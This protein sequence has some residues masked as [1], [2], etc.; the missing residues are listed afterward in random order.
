VS[1]RIVVFLKHENFDL[2]QVFLHDIFPIEILRLPFRHEGTDAGNR[3][4]PVPVKSGPGD[5]SNAGRTG[6][7][8]VASQKARQLSDVL[9]TP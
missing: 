5:K 1:G 7:Q 2:A 3:Q 4:R 6:E 9:K 8:T